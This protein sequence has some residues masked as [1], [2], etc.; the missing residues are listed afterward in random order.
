DLAYVNWLESSDEIIYVSERDG[1]RHLYHVDA[2]TGATTQITKGEF[3]LRGIDAIDEKRRQIYFRACGRNPGEDPYFTHYYR[4]DFDG[5]HLTA[6]TQ[7]HGSH[8]LQY[9]PSR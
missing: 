8:R 9:S 2:R 5:R 6:L 3:V 7:G 1:W 4:V